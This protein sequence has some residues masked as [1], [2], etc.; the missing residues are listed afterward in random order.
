MSLIIS[1]TTSSNNLRRGPREVSKSNMF[2]LQNSNSTITR[3]PD[4]PGS[5]RFQLSAYFCTLFLVRWVPGLKSFNL[6]D[7]MNL[8]V[9]RGR[10]G[11]GSG[12]VRESFGVGS[13]LGV[14]V[15]RVFGSFFER[16]DGFGSSDFAQIVNL[17]M[18]YR[19]ILVSGTEVVG[20]GRVEF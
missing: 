9:V 8:G 13:G 14:R 18:L 20:R 5:S 11:R 4:G 6:I 15:G 2:R 1:I 3:R 7:F 10:F 16:P 19:S 17:L 12:K